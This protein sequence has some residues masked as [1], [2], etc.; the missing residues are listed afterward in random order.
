MYGVHRF[1]KKTAREQYNTGT[2]ELREL[3][4]IYYAKI[5][6]TR[7]TLQYNIRNLS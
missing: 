2:V 5:T 3:S 1:A 6:R 4:I 7:Y